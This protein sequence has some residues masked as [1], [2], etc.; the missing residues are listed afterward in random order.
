MGHFF[1]GSFSVR[2]DAKNRFVLPQ[3]FRYGLVEEGVLQFCIAMGLG[4]SLAIYKKSTMARIVQRLQ[5]KQY[6]GKYQKFFTFFFSTL[7]ETTCDRLGRILLPQNL[8]KMAGIRNEIVI[9]GVLDRVEIWP[10]EQFDKQF[11]DIMEAKDSQSNWN[12]LLGEVFEGV[13][14]EEELPL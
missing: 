8:K 3:T 10:K 5:A 14:A 2:I 1:S 9:A 13:G 4:G 6:S 7:H 11:K 12:E